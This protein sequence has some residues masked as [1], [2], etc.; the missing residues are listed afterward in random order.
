MGQ[1][2]EG[3]VTPSSSDTVF[4][5]EN[6]SEKRETGNAEESRDNRRN[7]VFQKKR[8]MVYSPYVISFNS[9]VKV[10]SRHQGL[11]I[12]DS[13]FTLTLPRPRWHAH[14]CLLELS[15]RK[16]VLV[17]LCCFS[18]NTRDWVMCKEQNLVSHGSGGRAV[19]DLGASR[20]SVW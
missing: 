19:Q 4:A 18:K 5:H 6:D 1:A 9:T 8:G 16:I 20:F 3:E 7:E 14:T 13:L 10:P 2:L 17:R 15:P 11:P 12:A